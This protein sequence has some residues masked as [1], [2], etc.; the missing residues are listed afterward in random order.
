VAQSYPGDPRFTTQ[1]E[2]EVWERL[3]DTLP[4]DALL[5]ANLRIV[6]EEKDHE[7]DLVVLV[8]GAG[9]VVLEVKGGSVWVEDGPDGP[10]WFVGNGRGGQRRVRPVEQ[11]ARSKYAWREYVESDPRWGSRGRVAWAHG[12]VTP[13]SDFPD[14]FAT[15][16]CP[17]WLLHDRG[18]QAVLAARVAD[19]AARGGHGG[20]PPTVEDLELVAEIVRGRGFTRHDLNADAAER[21]A[22]ADRLTAEQAALLQVTRLLHRVEIR[23]G[24]GSGKTVLA[25]A[26]ARQLSAGREGTPPQRVGLLCY[27][28]G[29]AEYFKR[30]VAQWPKR[31]RP[32]YVGTYED[33]GRLWGAP[34]G[35]R[36]DSDFWERQLPE[37]MAELAGALPG[38]QKFDA[39]IVDEAQDFADLWWTPLLRALRDEEEGGLY[40]YSDE[41]QRIFARFGQPPVPLVPLV[42]DHNLRNT[43]QV[44]QAFGPLAPTRMTPRGGE[45]FDVTFVPVSPGQDAISA[46]DDAIEMLLDV[47][48]H[49]GNIALLTTGSRHP[50]QINRTEHDG[51][52]GYWRSY[53]DDDVFYGHVL[54]CKGLERP[55][56]VLCVNESEAKD[57]AKEKLYVGM[58]RATDQLIVVGDPAVVREMGGP[59][60]AARLGI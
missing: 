29:L 1:S 50:E 27:S 41:N 31:Q 24:A 22:T 28:I 13:Y 52:L 19:N 23:G 11:A 49:P 35:S 43:R 5:L 38:E 42:L 46:A 44:Y 54:G 57:R 9:V 55:A 58:S 45:G 21:Q 40:V 8:P 37:R 47:G 30:E 51:Q 4:A 25:L 14:D 2:R 53:W 48:W 18:D 17:R 6:D 32:A 33:L 39:F 15:P 60:V 7:S 10:Q 16:D 26:Q 56:V 59:A 12:V 34:T 36:E 20:R 3:R